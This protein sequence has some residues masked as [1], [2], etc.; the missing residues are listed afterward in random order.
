MSATV[1]RLPVNLASEKQT[2]CPIRPRCCLI[3][4]P[5]HPGVPSFHELESEV[6]SIPDENLRSSRFPVVFSLASLCMPLMPDQGF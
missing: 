4:R 3:R 5:W 2:P 6:K 1:S